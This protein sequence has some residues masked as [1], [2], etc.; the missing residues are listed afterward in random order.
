MVYADEDEIDWSDGSFSA[1]SPIPI[2]ATA[3]PTHP[4][5]FVDTYDDED[6]LFVSDTYD[7]HQIPYVPPLDPGK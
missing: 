7:Q 1:A 2:E 4:N 5:P 6:S 3:G